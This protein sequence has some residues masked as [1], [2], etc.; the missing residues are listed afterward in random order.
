MSK[1]T[2]LH[3]LVSSN[4]HRRRGRSAGLAALLASVACAAIAQDARAAGNPATGTYEVR[5][6]RDFAGSS[7]PI[8]DGFGGW[9]A[10]RSIAN[11]SHVTT[12]DCA[13]GNGSGLVMAVGGGTNPVPLGSYAGW[14]WSAPSNTEIAEVTVG[15]DGF[16]RPYD[17]INQ[18]VFS[19]GG[20]RTG[21]IV[22]R[23]GAG[24]TNWTTMGRG[25]M[26]DSQLV[27]RVACDGPSGHV[28]CPAGPD[29]ARARVIIS[30]FSLADGIAPSAGAISGSAHAN[31]T[32][33]G[34]QAFNYA[35]TDLGGGIL[36]LRMYVDGQP[37]ITHIVDD[38][39]G[40]CAPVWST[41]HFVFFYPRP[42]PLSVNATE[43][44][45]TNTLAD[46]SHDVTFKVMDTAMREATLYSGTKVVA[47]HPPVNTASPAYLRA[48]DAAAPVLGLSLGVSDGAWDGPNLSYARAWLQCDASGAAC[49]QIPGAT[50]VGY[51]P[52]TAD[53]GHRLRY[54]VT[55]TNAAES[56]TAY[57]PLTGLV[58]APSSADA[59]VLKPTDGANGA[60]GANGSHGGSAFGTIVVPG[61][62]SW[63]N[64]SKLEH[65]FIGRVA[66]ER[67]GVPCP[68]DKATLVFEHVTGGQ[69]KLRY[70]AETTAQVL[71][72]CTVTG[73]A[74]GDAKLEIAT[75]TG[76]QAAVASD[77]T[78][79]GS[80]HATLRL[81]KG[82]S[83]GITVG[84]RMFADDPLARATAS[85]KVLV[86]GLVSLTASRGS[87]HN[88]QAVT[89]RGKLAGG[90][91]PGRGV[92]LAVQWK[93]GRR[94][95]PFAQI[96]TDR[97]G[98]FRYAYR[99]TRTTRK[100]TYRL[101]V[102]VVK[103]QVDYP[104]G[105]VASKAVRVTVAH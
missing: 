30:S 64:A 103:G 61:L 31:G 10:E 56:V 1:G 57:S 88:G 34:S 40:H 20:D 71:L 92:H 29:T 85:L 54:A 62:N 77:V 96:K 81:A 45:D 2:T 105:A 16:T 32:W 93:D 44:I 79:D 38:F 37:A 13:S 95:R 69:V 80:G 36:Q 50:G 14:T 8:N 87:L 46:G 82:A 5:A 12:N 19:I 27:A 9:A 66:G 94:W 43:T 76:S 22:V 23:Q 11:D 3:L 72:T 63:T 100:V 59:P 98:A 78:T 70:G 7:L 47:N 101:R 89:L 52:T 97:T 60:N 17:G 42:C 55:A 15:F 90:L 41:D 74:I 83:R 84:Y 21:D 33:K 99:F 51:T 26:H 28:G 86:D 18:G 25:G 65:T 68:Q 39:G 102:Q 75:K 58:A 24:S 104:F 49:V 35:A 4:A 67:D 91:V 48:A 6:C 73:K 53:V